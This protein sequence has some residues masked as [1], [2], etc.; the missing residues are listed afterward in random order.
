MPQDQVLRARRGTDGVGLYEAEA[1]DG[2]REGGLRKKRLRNC[3]R[4]QIL[5]GA[6]GFDSRDGHKY[7]VLTFSPRSYFA[8]SLGSKIRTTRSISYFGGQ[9]SLPIS[10]C[11]ANLL[12]NAGSSHD[13]TSMY[14]VRPCASSHDRLRSS[15]AGSSPPHATASFRPWKRTAPLSHTDSTTA[16]AGNRSR[17]T[18]PALR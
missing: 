3:V 16:F 8:R 14:G 12:R 10:L 4:S 13:S 5:Q 1:F 18:S 15:H 11:A 7:S 17:T 9:S 2:I 6:T